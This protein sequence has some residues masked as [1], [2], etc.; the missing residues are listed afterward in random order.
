MYSIFFAVPAYIETESKIIDTKILINETAQLNCVA[1]GVPRVKVRWFKDGKPLN[2]ANS[3][4]EFITDG[5]QFRVRGEELSDSGI[6]TCTATNKVGSDKVE[7]RLSVYGM[8]IFPFFLYFSSN[9]PHKYISQY[10]YEF[11]RR[12]DFQLQ[13]SKLHNLFSEIRIIFS[14]LLVSM[15]SLFYYRYK[16]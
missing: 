11:T 13:F 12:E 10:V 2:S 6:Y 1:R 14:C 4:I 7:Y 3:R 8:F 5:R 16:T 15:S 9:E